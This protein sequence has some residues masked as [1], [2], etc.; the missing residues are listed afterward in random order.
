ML[1]FISSFFPE[2]S[3]MVKCA[4]AMSSGICT[5]L[6]LE[7]GALMVRDHHTENLSGARVYMCDLD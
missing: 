1:W 3:V 7:T 6:A 4:A 5:S 2:V